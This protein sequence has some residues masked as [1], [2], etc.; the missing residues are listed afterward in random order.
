MYKICL[1]MDIHRMLQLPS[2]SQLVAFT[3]SSRLCYALK[4]A[5]IMVLA[6]SGIYL[7]L[8]ESHEIS[9]SV[10]QKLGI[11]HLHLSKAHYF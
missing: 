8:F 3:H 1:N 5:V 4:T 6:I 11:Y 9:N 10:G 7:L 2:Y